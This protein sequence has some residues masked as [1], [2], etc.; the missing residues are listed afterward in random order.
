MN[1][2]F[3]ISLKNISA[4]KPISIESLDNENVFIESDVGLITPITKCINCHSINVLHR[5]GCSANCSKPKLQH[6]YMDKSGS[7]I[8]QGK[9]FSFIQSQE[10]LKPKFISL[11]EINKLIQKDKI[12]I[13]S[14]KINFDMKDIYKNV[15]YVAINPELQEKQDLR[16]WFFNA[17]YQLG[18]DSKQS[19]VDRGFK[20]YKVDGEYIVINSNDHDSTIYASQLV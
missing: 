1:N 20:L 5:F 11:T 19:I 6:L 7:I 17:M 12:F 18:C 10:H 3:K 4:L 13:R 9:D 14:K 15:S 8:E 2:P 16:V